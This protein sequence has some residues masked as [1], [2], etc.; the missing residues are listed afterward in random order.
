MKSLLLGLAM[1]AS[2][3]IGVALAEDA[4]PQAAT[5]ST[6]DAASD[7]ERVP[8]ANWLFVQVGQSFTSDGKSLTINGVAPKTLMFADRPERTTG[9]VPTKS[10]VGYWTEGEDDFAE[11]PP[12][13]TVSTVI[14]GKPDLAVVELRNPR[15]KGDSI[16]YDIHPL[17][18]DLPATGNQVSL[19]IDWWRG[20]GGAWHRGGWGRSPLG[21]GSG[22]GPLGLGARSVGRRRLLAWSLGPSPLQLLVMLDRIVVGRPSLPPSGDVA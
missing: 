11:D 20:P 1:A 7:K 21:S 8:V 12:N 5:I 19:F 3:T 22:A 2:A 10:L 9:D 13:A 18:G 4:P 6:A 15:V 16:T 17:D 14:D